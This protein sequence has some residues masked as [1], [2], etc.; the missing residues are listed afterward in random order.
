MAKLPAERDHDAK[1]FAFDESGRMLVEI[2]SPY[3]VYSKPDRQLGA[4]G[5]GR[6]RV[7]EDIWWILA[8]RRQQAESDAG[9]R[10][11]LLHR[12]SPC[13]G[14][15]VAPG[16]QSFFMAQMGRDNLN[17][18]DPEHYDELDN[19]ERVSEVMHHVKKDRTSAGRT[20]TI[21][22]RSRKRACCAG[23]RRRQHQAS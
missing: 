11:A 13:V 9:R 18:V 19:A 8:V 12:P 16:V 5:D 10:R 15:R 22:I 20:A 21:G 2:G 7:S 17:V 23:V 3:N 1:A 4:K 14:A 6:D